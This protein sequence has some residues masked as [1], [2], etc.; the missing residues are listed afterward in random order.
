MT[1]CVKL[2]KN[3]S[4]HHSDP[5]CG[6][7][8]SYCADR[9]HFAYSSTHWWACG[10]FHL[11]GCCAYAHYFWTSSFVCC[12]EP[13][14]LSWSSLRWLQVESLLPLGTTL[15]PSCSYPVTSVPRGHS[16]ILLNPIF[17]KVA[18]PKGTYCITPS[19]LRLRSRDFDQLRKERAIIP[20]QLVQLT[21]ILLARDWNLGFLCLL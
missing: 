17:F 4:E 14:H 16:C 2:T 18:C 12:S 6:Q 15:L 21:N 10:C 19:L 5:F 9:V 8:V 13:L 3:L 11:L 1:S 20:K 7:I